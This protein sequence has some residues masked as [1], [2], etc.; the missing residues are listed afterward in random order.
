MSWGPPWSRWVKGRRL[1]DDEEAET[2]AGLGLLVAPPTL[3][4]RPGLREP[5]ALPPLLGLPEAPLISI[6][7]EDLVA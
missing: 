4:D 2:G 6:G 3:P 7:L 1:A 5:L